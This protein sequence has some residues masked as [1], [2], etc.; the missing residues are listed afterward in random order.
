MLESGVELAIGESVQMADR[1]LTVVDIQGDEIT[2]RVDYIDEFPGGDLAA[3][4]HKIYQL[5][6]R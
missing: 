1:I 4:D 3:L 6:P 2:F 5:P